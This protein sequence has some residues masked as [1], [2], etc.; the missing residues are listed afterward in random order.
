MAS[1]TAAVLAVSATA[2]MAG[3]SATCN[4]RWGLALMIE[5]VGSFGCCRRSVPG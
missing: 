4:C 5:D 3:S 1:A 2:S